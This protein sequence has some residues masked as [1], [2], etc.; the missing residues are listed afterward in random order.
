VWH[1]NWVWYRNA[2]ENRLADLLID[3]AGRQRASSIPTG[4]LSAAS[5]TDLREAAARHLPAAYRALVA[6]MREPFLQTIQ[7]LFVRRMA[8]GRIALVG[9]AAFIPRP[10]PRRPRATRWRLSTR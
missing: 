8:V 5:E 4:L 2:A 3:A 1:Y 6:A 10:V 9:D 7:D